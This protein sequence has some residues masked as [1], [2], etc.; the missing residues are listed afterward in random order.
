MR[1][2]LQRVKEASVSVDGALVSEIGKGML[3]FIG[4]KKGDTTVE[5]EYLVQRCANLRIFSDENNNMNLSVKNIGGGALVVSQFTLYA[6]TGKGNR[7]GFSESAPAEVA[8]PLYQE[9][10]KLLT[11]EVGQEKVKAG[12]FRAMMDIRLVNDGPVTII[13]ESKEISK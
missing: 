4:I 13:V 1:V 8:E 11:N 7:P 12:V 3:I 5:V 10:I 9:F 2:L 6:G